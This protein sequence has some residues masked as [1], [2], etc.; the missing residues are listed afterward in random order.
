MLTRWR[1]RL[2]GQDAARRRGGVTG[3]RERH[4][5][6]GL[7]E[8]AQRGR[9]QRHDR[10]VGDIAHLLVEL[11]Q[12]VAERGGPRRPVGLGQPVAHGEAGGDEDAARAEQ[13]PGRRG[14]APLDEEAR[15]AAAAR[16]QREKMIDHALSRC[17]SISS[18]PRSGAAGTSGWGTEKI[19]DVESLPSLSKWTSRPSFQIYVEVPSLLSATAV[20]DSPALNDGVLA[21]HE[22]LGLEGEEAD[23]VGLVAA[24]RE[25]PE[26]HRHPRDARG[27]PVAFVHPLQRV[28]ALDLGA[29]LLARLAI[30]LAHLVDGG[31]AGLD[32]APVRGGRG[33]PQSAPARA[34]GRAAVIRTR[35]PRRR[36]ADRRRRA[37]SRRGT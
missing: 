33:R 5:G 32:A 21:E 25:E 13:R 9:Q 24:R 30:A 3:R 23:Q 26:V 12:R 31:D 6:R 8:R 4:D 29:R 22:G 18:A 11:A 16:V 10:L 20:G 1:R 27:R 17:T 2:L 34:A 35:W 14:G 36:R 28:I 37:G 15:D 19:I 7:A